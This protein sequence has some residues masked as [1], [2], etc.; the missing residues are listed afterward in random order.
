MCA[1]DLGGPRLDLA[2]LDLDGRA[3]RPAHQVV[4]VVVGAAPVQRFAGV[5]A[6]RV[7]QSGGGH[8]LQRAVDGGQPDALAAA[9]R[10]SSCSSWADRNSSSF[11]SSAE[12]AARCLVERTRGGGPRHRCTPRRLRRRGPRRR[13]RCRR[14]GGRRG[15]TCTSRPDAFACHDAGGL[16]DAQ[17]LADQ[18]LGDRERVDEFVHAARRFAQLQHDRDADRGGQR[19][20][21][22]AGG[23]EHLAG[24]SSW[25]GV[26]LCWCPSTLA[27]GASTGNRFHYERQITCGIAHVNASLRRGVPRR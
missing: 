3:A 22:I 12:M 1:S 2:A 9:L 21:Q 4:M 11:S 13:A 10:N 17:M 26:P 23:V 19:A 8:R 7:D 27:S 16:Q 18:R 24:G 5:G 20:Q 25:A 15:G 14:G 6:Q